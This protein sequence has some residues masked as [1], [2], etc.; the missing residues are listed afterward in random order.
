MCVPSRWPWGHWLGPVALAWLAEGAGAGGW[1]QLVALGDQE[2]QLHVPRGMG[3]SSHILWGMWDVRGR[4][5][6]DLGWGCE[7]QG[8]LGFGMGM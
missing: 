3:W 4:G 5:M 8:D 2:L 1:G 7:G 6:W